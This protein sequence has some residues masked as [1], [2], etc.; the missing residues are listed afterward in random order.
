MDHVDLLASM[1]ANL[2]YILMRIIAA[3]SK[4]EGIG[5]NNFG[6]ELIVTMNVRVYG[7]VSHNQI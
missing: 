7:G 2:V 4:E 3:S 1:Q 5:Q 6:P